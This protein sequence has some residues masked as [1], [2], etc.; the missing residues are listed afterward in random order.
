MLSQKAS[1]LCL[2][3]ILKRFSDEDHPISTEKIIEKMKMIY[4]LDMERRA[5]YRNISVLNE[6]GIEIGKYSDNRGGYCLLEHDFELSEI[7]LL[8][9]AV[10]SSR[11]IPESE[12]KK[13]I[14]KL[15]RTQSIFRAGAL[16]GTIYIKPRQRAQNMKIFYNIDMLNIAITGCCCAR[17][18]ILKYTS[19]KT[20]EPVGTV[21]FSPYYTVWADDNYYVICRSEDTGEMCHYRLDRLRNITVLEQEATPADYGF[22][23]AEY[24]H[25][26]IYLEGE[27]EKLHSI[28]CPACKLD[29]LIE[30]FGSDISIKADTDDTFTA[31]C[32]TTEKKVKIWNCLYA[33]Q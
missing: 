17:G 2:W 31:F 28:T 4:D 23:P 7:R 12:S 33:D 16:K 6:M 13:L 27:R 14:K 21:V 32:K 22:S 25:K 10:A 29:E 30:Y 19:D 11:F 1:I 3:D 20:L 15:L 24:T 26:M 9:D 18:E 5:V 8:C